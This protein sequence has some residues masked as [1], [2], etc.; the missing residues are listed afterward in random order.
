MNEAL[1][2]RFLA[3]AIR[4]GA[5]ALGSTW[6]NPAV[7][8]IIVKDGQVVGRG[9]TGQGGRPHGEVLALEMA[10][11]NARGATLYVSLEP[12][13]HFGKTPPCTNA[14]VAAGIERVVATTTDPDPRVA[15]KG[16]DRLRNAG[17]TVSA[18]LLADE[19]KR[20]QAGHIRRMQGGRPLVVLKLAVS[21][22]DAIGRRGEGQVTVTGEI[23]RRH[24]QALRSRFDAI[25][26]GSG[27]IEA[28]NPA[29]T[30]R[31]PGLAHR[32]PVRVILDTEGE[33]QRD[34]KAFDAE[35]P[36]W[37]FSARQVGKDEV[38]VRRF[39]V[40]RSPEGLDLEACLGRLAEEGI[41]RLLVEGGAR[42][43]RSF[44]SAD[45][46]DEAILFHSDVSL[47]EGAV[48]ALADVPLTEI[49]ASPRFQQ[50]EQ[51]RFGD[52]R[53]RRYV[54]IH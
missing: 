33:L 2:R 43:A 38:S 49:E 41:T 36:T 39:I 16:L 5:S 28:D 12:C 7:G 37:V 20:A 51:R 1:D 31:L 29:L 27:T 45:L 15:G 34:R 35:A 53:M 40:P 3:A 46:V 47:G 13:A 17:V 6:P 10:G 14:I 24:V 9:R 21:A 50:I 44:L 11:E 52:D 19:A 22:D 42:V 32:S 54:R 18:G 25:L 4:L 26:V 30:C 48:P 8:A 23:A